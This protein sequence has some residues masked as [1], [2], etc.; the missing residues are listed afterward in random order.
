MQPIEG[1][2]IVL[3][4]FNLPL[5]GEASP[6]HDNQADELL[7][8][9]DEH[10]LDLLPPPGS[11]TF[12]ERRGTA[13]IDLVFGTP[14]VQERVIF[15]GVRKDLTISRTTCQWHQPS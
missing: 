4:D 10:Q 6:R 3:G 13:T 2:R 5:G 1:N 11:K 7:L 8:L 14:W 9:M 12:D 15:C